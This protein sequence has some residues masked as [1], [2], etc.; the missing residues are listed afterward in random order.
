MNRKR[1]RFETIFHLIKIQR[2]K[3]KAKNTL[4]IHKNS[5]L[6]KTRKRQNNF[7]ASTN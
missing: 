5:H 7:V 3:I 4:Q 2:R 6:M 1:L